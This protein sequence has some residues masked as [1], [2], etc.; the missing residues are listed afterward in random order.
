MAIRLALGAG[1]RRLVAQLLT[2]SLLLSFLGGAIALTVVAS[3]MKVLIGFL[4]PEIPRLNEI[5]ISAHRAWLR[6]L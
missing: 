3:V 1:R 6:L 4:P 2:E 5:G